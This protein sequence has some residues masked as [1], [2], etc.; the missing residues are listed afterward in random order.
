M[1]DFVCIF[2]GLLSEPSIHRILNAVDTSFSQFIRSGAF[3][4]ESIGLLLTVRPDGSRLHVLLRSLL[5][6][7]GLSFFFLSWVFSP[8]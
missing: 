8:T 3:N 7:G 4:M 1:D 6:T 2:G 5:L